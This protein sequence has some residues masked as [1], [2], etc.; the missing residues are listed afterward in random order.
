MSRMPRDV[1]EELG[2]RLYTAG[3][4][5][6]PDADD[7]GTLIGTRLWRVR[8]GYVEYL[9]LRP[10]GLAYAVRAEATFDYQRPAQHGRI[11][12]YLSG[13]GVN[14]LDWLLA[15][16]EVERPGCHGGLV[17]GSSPVSVMKASMRP[18]RYCIRLRRVFT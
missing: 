12:E 18:G 2:Q 16:T 3:F 6:L 9:A 8:A 5:P 13:Y 15:T 11:V 14:A 7:G 17:A 1:A 10:S 4:R